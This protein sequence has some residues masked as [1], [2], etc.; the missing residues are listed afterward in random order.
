MELIV[1]KYFTDI[2]DVLHMVVTNVSQDG[3]RLLIS[4]RDFISLSIVIPCA[5][6]WE[7]TPS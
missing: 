1:S 3:G 6:R 5:D 2:L 7:M 4:N